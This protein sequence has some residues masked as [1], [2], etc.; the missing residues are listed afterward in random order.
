MQLESIKNLSQGIRDQ[1]LS[2]R[3]ILDHLESIAMIQDDRIQKR[4]LEELIREYVLLEKRVDTLLK[5]TLPKIV[6]E[7]IKAKGRF[8]PRSYDCTIIFTDIVGFS[9]MAERIPGK[10]LI[11]LLNIICRGLD[12]LVASYRGT[13]I[14]TIGDAYMAVFGAPRKYEDH[15]LMA[16]KTGLETLRLVDLFNRHYEQKIGVRIGIHTGSVMAGVIGKDR[17][18]FDIFGDNVN[19]ASRF[20]SS[21]SEG[22]VN[23]SQETYL[24]TR[25]FFE[26]EER[27]EIALKNKGNMKAYFVT[28]E[29]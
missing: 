29:L 12:D 22:K 17:M 3:M 14:K 13:K 27:G 8:T 28:R 1:Q 20:E 15:A 16:V 4:L 5:N 7:E 11:E 24:R 21:G 23:V 26:F 2:N 6:A 19:I 18:Q 10:R 25:D 9:R